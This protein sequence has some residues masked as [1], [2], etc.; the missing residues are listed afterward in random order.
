MTMIRFSLLAPP[1]FMALLSGCD[2]YRS[3]PS[4]GEQLGAVLGV[5]APSPDGFYDGGIYDQD[6]AG[7]T[8]HLH[9]QP[10]EFH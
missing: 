5:E 3:R 10:G 9:S 6:I 2:G 1:L 4:G 7:S 8:T